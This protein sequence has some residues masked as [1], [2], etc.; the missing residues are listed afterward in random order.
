MGKYKNT[1]CIYPWFYEDGADLIHPDDLERYKERFLYHQNCLLYC[2]DEDP[3]YI[4]VKHKEELF[5]VKPE[6]YKR[7]IIP[8][9]SY[10]EH[11]KLK[12]YPDAICVVDDLRWHYDRAEPIYTLI[13]DGKKK[14]RRYYEEEFDLV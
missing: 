13:V 14:S 2:I 6:L 8:R 10:G 1:W 12:K 5:R 7:V 11:L 9:Y 3:D 4:T